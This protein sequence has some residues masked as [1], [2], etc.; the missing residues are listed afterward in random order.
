[1]PL[2]WTSCFFIGTPTFLAS[3]L[4]LM[5]WGLPG[6]GKSINGPH[7]CLRQCTSRNLDCPPTNASVTVQARKAGTGNAGNSTI[8]QERDYNLF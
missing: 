4:F 3:V 8:I 5:K 1:M 6:R 7:V 2:A